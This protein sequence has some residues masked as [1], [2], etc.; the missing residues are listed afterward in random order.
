MLM[1]PNQDETA[2]HGCHSTDN[3]LCACVRLWPNH[4]DVFCD[5][6][7]HLHVSFLKRPKNAAQTI[8]VKFV[9]KKA[10]FKLVT[11]TQDTNL[12]VT[13]KHV[14]VGDTENTLLYIYN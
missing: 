2:V 7:S 4:G 11:V 9:T 6:L 1:S 14:K 10:T 13:A 12:P 8:V 5:F 3:R